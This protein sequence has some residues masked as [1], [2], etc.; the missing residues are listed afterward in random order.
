MLERQIQNLICYHPYLLDA[1]I[2]GSGKKERCISTGRIDIDFQTP[3]GIIVVECKISPLINRDV[4]QLRRHIR[5]LAQSGETVLKAYL[6]G[7]SPI[8]PL[9][10]GLLMESPCIAIAEL[11]TAIPLQLSFCRE[12]H[13]FDA[14]LATCPYDGADKLPGHDLSLL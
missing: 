9:D 11:V 13:Y 14:D 7:Q 8:R 12:G 10:L 4:L 2:C 1:A 5:D 6:V 3:E